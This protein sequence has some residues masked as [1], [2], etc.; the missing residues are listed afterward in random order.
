MEC[1]FKGEF[2]DREKERLEQAITRYEHAQKKTA[3][4]SSWSFI[5][6]K[7]PY[8]GSL[9]WGVR[10]DDGFMVKA[11][12]SHGLARAVHVARA[13]SI[14]RH[15]RALRQSR[16]ALHRAVRPPSASAGT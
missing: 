2:T 14:R 3:T 10:A 7:T 9:Y 16:R 13:E 15:G 11:G 1:R 12:T 4:A 8:R 5:H 6:F